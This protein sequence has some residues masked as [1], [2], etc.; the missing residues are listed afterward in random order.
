[1]KNTK[2]IILYKDELGNNIT[3][4][5]TE[6]KSRELFD[7]YVEKGR[8]SKETRWNDN[9]ELVDK[10]LEELINT[11]N[12]CGTSSEDS[13]E[14]LRCEVINVVCELLLDKFR[15]EK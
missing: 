13:I 10:V 9:V 5:D 2:D 7:S 6:M 11:T 4:L 1:M 8:F 3:I 15:M 12:F 14:N